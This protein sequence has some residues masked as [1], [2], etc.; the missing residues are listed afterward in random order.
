MRRINGRGAR[1]GKPDKHE[2]AKTI[3]QL[4]RGIRLLQ[5]IHARIRLKRMQGQIR[6][7]AT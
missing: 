1:H 2:P 3:V 5:Y 4:H 7:K 6:M